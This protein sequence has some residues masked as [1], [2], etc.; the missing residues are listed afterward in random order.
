ML[1]KGRQG[2]DRFLAKIDPGLRAAVIHGDDLGVV[3]DRGKS[4]ARQVTE[5]PDDP[6]DA[7]LLGDTDLSLDPARLETELTAISMMGGRRLVRLRLDEESKQLARA[8]EAL[9]DHLAGAFN[10]DAFFL[11]ETGRLRRD[12]PLRKV[13]EKSSL[14]AVLECYSDDIG[15]VKQLTRDVLAADGIHLTS[16]AL[17]LFVSRLPQERGVARQEI[18]RLALYL[19]PESRATAGPAD[20]TD[21]LGVEP[22]ASLAD[23]A[24][25]AFGGRLALA[26]AGL[27][28]AAQEGQRG[29]AVVRDVSL[30]LG[31]LRRIVTLEKSGVP[32][33]QAAKAAGVFWK[34][35]REMARQARMW[36]LSELDAIQAEALAA[37][38]SCKQAGAPDD[39]IAERLAFS[40]AG[41]ARRLG[42]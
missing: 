41:K 39:L 31:R 3:R 2:I 30:H 16:E 33:Q 11:I 14:C 19:G 40:V 18:E 34:N 5:R 13:S 37:D 22:E 38:Q 8:A 23:A 9:T 28:R 6:F 20:L 1:I 32:V 25:D 21:F 27:R 24:L 4:V 17:D 15:D 35:E 26:Q 12:A 36:S 7:A 29:P 42:L 10:P